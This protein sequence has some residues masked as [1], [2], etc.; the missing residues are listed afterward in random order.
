MKKRVKKQLYPHLR[1]GLWKFTF[2]YGILFFGLIW[3]TLAALALI[4]TGTRPIW[5]A[6][7]I[8]FLSGFIGGFFWGLFTWYFSRLFNKKKG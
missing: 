7:I 1:M 4:F 6:I 3:G 8:G 2:K 5:F